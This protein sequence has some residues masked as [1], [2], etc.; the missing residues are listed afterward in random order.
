V[1]STNHAAPIA[2]AGSDI[3]RTIPHHTFDR[4]PSLFGNAVLVL[5]GMALLITLVVGFS[6]YKSKEALSN[7]DKVPPSGATSASDAKDAGN[8]SAEGAASSAA[9]TVKPAAKPDPASKPQPGAKGIEEPKESNR[10]SLSESPGIEHS[11]GEGDFVAKDTVTYLDQRAKPGKSRP[12]AS[13]SRSRSHRD[14]VIAENTVT[15]SSGAAGPLKP[16]NRK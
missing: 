4:A 8:H 10:R 5:I 12:S 2:E 9:P 15:Y 13:N 7:R 16:A 11:A 14:G 3:P 6:F 1:S